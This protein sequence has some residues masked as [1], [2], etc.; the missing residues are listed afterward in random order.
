MFEGGEEV[1][2][3]GVNSDIG[4]VV[5]MVVVVKGLEGSG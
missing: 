2:I 5:V 4:W 3:S 1:L